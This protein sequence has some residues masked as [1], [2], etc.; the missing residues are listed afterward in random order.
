VAQG[1]RLT[2]AAVAVFLFGA[3]LP[4]VVFGQTA[5]ALTRVRA[6]LDSAATVAARSDA[7]LATARAA[8]LTLQAAV[9]SR[10]ATIVTLRDS[11]A[12]LL[13]K[14]TPPPP[15][16]PVVARHPNEPAGLTRVLEHD[17]AA[18]PGGLAGWWSTPTTTRL[19]I[20]A[21]GTAVA[22]PAAVLDTKLPNGMAS[23]VAPVTW[24]A[25]AEKLSTSS[26]RY[27]R[28][29]VSLWLK[30][31]GADFQ[32]QAVGTKLWYV[33]YGNTVQD[34]AGFLLLQGTGATA[35]QSAMKLQLYLSE[36]DDADGPSHAHG[37]NVDSRALVTV[38]A[39]H[40]LEVTLDA[41]TP[42]HADGAYRVWVDGVKVSESTAQKY[43]DSRHSF[44]QGFFMW[45]WTPV[46]GGMGGTRTRDDHLLV[47]H[48]YISGGN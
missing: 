23:G 44:T 2:L 47:D 40:H 34:N 30:I 29:Y 1:R 31:P 6:S 17:G 5:P 18:V 21:D 33:A 35:L 32:N 22:S 41:G 4:F 16:V 48:V 28:L 15:P 13:A 46:W 11:V 20:A 27:R 25:W 3:A 12:G 19:T 14:L 39:W 45:Q 7:D 26:P 42:D 38:G 8:V 37:Q 10:D 36:T 9:V 24:R 43:L